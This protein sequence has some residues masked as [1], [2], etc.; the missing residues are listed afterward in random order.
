VNS[1][2]LAPA[3]GTLTL[4]TLMLT[5]TGVVDLSLIT[6]CRSLT[7]LFLGH[8]QID[9]LEPLAQLQ[10]LRELSIAYCSR[11]TT[12][13]PLQACPWLQRLDIEGSGVRDSGVERCAVWQQLPQLHFLN[14]LAR[15]RRAG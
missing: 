12:V 15:P 14:G 13:E 8:T 10:R 5:S 2:G 6:C 4:A 11:V 9:S 7:S 3:L 1:G